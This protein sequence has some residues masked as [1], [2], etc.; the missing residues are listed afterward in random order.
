MTLIKM[1]SL[2]TE[3]YF[4]QVAFILVCQSCMAISRTTHKNECGHIYIHYGGAIHLVGISL[5]TTMLSK[6]EQ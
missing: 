1:G 4:R 2:A 6:C 5:I 3:S